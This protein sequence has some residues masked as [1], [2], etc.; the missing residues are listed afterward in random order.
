VLI[1]LKDLCHQYVNTKN[2][3]SYQFYIPELDAMFYADKELDSRVTYGHHSVFDMKAA[4]EHATLT[5]TCT[6]FLKSQVMKDGSVVQL[7]KPFMSGE[8]RNST[9]IEPPKRENLFRSSSYSSVIEGGIL[10][11]EERVVPVI[12]TNI[13]VPGIK[14]QSWFVCLFVCSCG[15]Q[16]LPFI[17]LG[18]FVLFF[19][20]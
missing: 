19:G 11:R 13:T 10:S 20:L 12:P 4:K 1:L 7:V 5:I 6:I 17:R 15:G 8:E 14:Y 2:S 16:D 18:L 9:T 3:A